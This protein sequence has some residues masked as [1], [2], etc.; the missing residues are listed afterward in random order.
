[1]QHRLTDTIVWR[2][3]VINIGQVKI[4]KGQL[5]K[6]MDGGVGWRV[7]VINIVQVKRA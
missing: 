3:E 1:M 7:K 6:K 2:A 4:V 5:K